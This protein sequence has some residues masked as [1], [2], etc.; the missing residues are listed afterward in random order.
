MTKR[1]DTE[2]RGRY[3]S[4]WHELKNAIC[5]FS[6]SEL[7]SDSRGSALESMD[8]VA[9]AMNSGFK[10]VDAERQAATEAEVL[11]AWREGRVTIHDWTPA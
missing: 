11:K 7:D 1:D 4:A 6:I 9:N 2:K 10:Q 5:A 3:A 8:Y